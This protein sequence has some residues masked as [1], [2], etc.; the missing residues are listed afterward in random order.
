MSEGQQSKAL[1]HFLDLA[2]IGAERG[3]ST[4]EKQAYEL[5]RAVVDLVPGLDPTAVKGLA[6]FAE[7]AS[8]YPQ[9]AREWIEKA[10]AGAGK[11]GR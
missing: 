1:E 4:S 3:S 7:L 11:D 5:A 10:A 6:E 9:R 2:A 8:R